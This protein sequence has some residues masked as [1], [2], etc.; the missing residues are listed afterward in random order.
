MEFYIGNRIK[1]KEYQAIPEQ[2]RTRAI[3]RLCGAVGTVTDKLWSENDNGF[4]YRVHLDG[5][6]RPSSKLWLQEHLDRYVEPSVEYKC[7]FDVTDDMV[8]AVLYET[9]DH[10]KVEIARARGRIIYEGALGVAQAYSYALR[11]IY[12]DLNGGSI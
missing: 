2:H 9:T 8:V 3:G 4:V 11:R 1:I 5:Y 10:S 12:T 6:D 7:E